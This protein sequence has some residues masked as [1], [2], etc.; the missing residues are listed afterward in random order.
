VTTRLPKPR[1]REAYA[2]VRQLRDELYRIRAEKPG[3]GYAHDAFVRYMRDAS[4]LGLNPTTLN[5]YS[6]N[7]VERFFA[8]TIPGPDGHVYWDGRKEFRRNDDKQRPPRRWWWEHVHGPIGTTTLRIHPI[9]GDE[10]CINPDHAECR[11]FAPRKF[12]DEQLI[13]FIKVAALRLGH[14]P[15][16]PEFDAQGFGVTARGVAL[17][18]GRS[19]PTALKAAGYKPPGHPK[20]VTPAQC[21]TALQRARALLGHWPSS[22]EFRYH[23][24]IRPAL[25]KE[26]L[27]AWP[28]TIR[29][30]LGVWHEALRKAGKR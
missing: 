20:K 5:Q 7:E 15:R 23:P 17:R 16:I 24:E 28:E 22:D 6:T 10:A 18:F 11:H 26:G 19:W 9:C 3:S 2:H 8:Y 29:G 1:S 21:I 4:R 14:P 12:T 27:P 30:A 25:Q 13:G